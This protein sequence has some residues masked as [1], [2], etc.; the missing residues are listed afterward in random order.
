MNNLK[1]LSSLPYTV[2]L[3]VSSF[4]SEEL[5]TLPREMGLINS[6][7]NVRVTFHPLYPILHLRSSNSQPAYSV[8]IEYD[9]LKCQLTGQAWR[10]KWN[11]LEMECCSS[12]TPKNQHYLLWEDDCQL[13]FSRVKSFA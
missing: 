12:L 1:S 7:Q 3:Y 9:R 13:P 2:G 10:R 5:Y 4:I 8:S 11:V 6:V